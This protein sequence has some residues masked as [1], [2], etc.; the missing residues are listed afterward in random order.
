MTEPTRR[1]KETL[2]LIRSFQTKGARRRRLYVMLSYLGG[3]ALLAIVVALVVVALPSSG[4]RTDPALTTSSSPAAAAP[5]TTTSAST[6]TTI[7]ETTTTTGSTTTLPAAAIASSTSTSLRPVTTSPATTAATSPSHTGYVV[8]IDPGHQARANYSTE[9]V[10]PGSTD[11]KAK[12]SSGTKSVNTGSP[13]SKLVLTIGLKLRDALEARGIKVVMTR[14]TQDVDISNSQRAQMANAAGADLFVRIHANGA[15]DSSAHGISVLYP[16]SIKGWTDDI[17]VDSKRAA[18][19]ALQ[20]LIAATGARSAGLS[21]RSDMTGFNWSD[22]PV[23]LPELG[24]MTN[25]A[26]DAQLATGAYQDKIA[27]GLTR[28]IL[29]Y[30]GVG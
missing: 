23:F 13:E 25:R 21:A 12:V 29:S 4:D 17:A 3:A 16:P 18:A 6:T 2:D 7:T 15:T 5:S 19:L 10:G 27:Q 14:T 22:V 20:E 28:A 26:E 30:L 24:F 9:P 11:M 8:A 1:S